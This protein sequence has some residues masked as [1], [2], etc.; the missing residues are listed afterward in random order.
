MYGKSLYLPFCFVVILK[1]FLKKIKS[2]DI[3]FK[4]LAKNSPRAPCIVS[5]KKG[6]SED[7]QNKNTLINYS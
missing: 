1:L 5:R 4:M 3:Y 6:D 2:Q 7:H